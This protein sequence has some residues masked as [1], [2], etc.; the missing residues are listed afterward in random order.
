MITGY[1]VSD[2]LHPCSEAP[3]IKGSTWI[4][5]FFNLRSVETR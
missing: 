2:L 1:A 4:I 5:A 3:R